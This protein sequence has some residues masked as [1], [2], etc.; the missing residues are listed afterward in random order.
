MPS[1]NWDVYFNGLFRDFLATAESLAAGVPAEV[2][3][4]T[5][6]ESDAEATRPQFVISHEREDVPNDE[7]YQAR[8]S[9]RLMTNEA[10]GSDSYEE[11]EG[12]LQ[13]VRDRLANETAVRA[14][15]AALDAGVA[16][17]WQPVRLHVPQGAFTKVREEGKAYVTLSFEFTWIVVIR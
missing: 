16:A 12:W 10:E 15:V 1:V 13:S 6:Q 2:P 8:F 17:G 5:A 9:V 4:T 7:V 3:M 14:Y 11:S